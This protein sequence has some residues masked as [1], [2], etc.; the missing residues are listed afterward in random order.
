MKRKIKKFR[1]KLATLKRHFP[2]IEDVVDSKRAV[3]V[4]V[5][6]RDCIKGKSKDP[7]SCA[8]AQAARRQYHADGVIIGMR[9]SYIVRGKHAIR[10]ATPES[11]QREIVSFD[12]HGDFDPGD[13]HLSPVSASARL[14]TGGGRSHGEAGKHKTRA[15][16]YTSRVR[17]V[18]R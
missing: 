8:L 10:F 13:Y 1:G 15:R 6:P 11:V 12:R 4:Q 14:G 3:H 18:E 2:K 7:G 5:Q 16:H 9:F 17:V